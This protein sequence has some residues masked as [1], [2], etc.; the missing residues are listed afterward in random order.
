MIKKKY[1]VCGLHCTSCSLVIEGELEDIGVQAS[2]DFA[3]EILEVEYNEEIIS[4]EA[5]SRAV[6]SAGYTIISVG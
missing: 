2:C 5:I 3:K 6:V 4:E 1:N